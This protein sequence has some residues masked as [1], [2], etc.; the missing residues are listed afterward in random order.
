MT[1]AYGDNDPSIFGWLNN[2][3]K[4]GSGYLQADFNSYSNV[5][6]VMLDGYN[7]NFDKVI[8]LGFSE[9]LIKAIEVASQAPK[10]LKKE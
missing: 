9:D 6:I 2:W 4:S 1:G 8:Q 7:D 5:Y 10:V 3:V